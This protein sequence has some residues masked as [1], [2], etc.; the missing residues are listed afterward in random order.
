MV[1]RRET[2]LFSLLLAL[3]FL[4]Y[5]VL[6]SANL[7]VYASPDETANAV[8][9]NQLATHGR[10]WLPESDAPEFAWLHPR[11]WVALNDRIAPVGFLGWPLFVA[12][13]RFVLGP[14]ILPWI[15]ALILLSAAWPFFR[16]LGRFGPAA[17]WI[18]TLVAFTHPSMIL[19]ANRGLFPNG[20]LLAGAIWS[21]W[22]L[23][24][25]AS[26]RLRR[27]WFFLTGAVMAL[28]VAIRPLEALWL[29]PWWVW[30]GWPWKFDRQRIAALFV[31][32]ALVL[33]PT[34]VV[35]D[36]T[37]GSPFA[38]GYWVRSPVVTPTSEQ[39]LATPPSA[40]T[41][42]EPVSRIS[43]LLPFGLH[44][45]AIAWN[46]RHFLLGLVW[47]WTAVLVIAAFLFLRRHRWSPPHDHRGMPFHLAF[48]TVLVLLAVYGSGRYADHVR[49]DAVT[50]ANSFLRY[51][52]PLAPLVGWAIA[53]I[54]NA[55]ERV[56]LF[57][58]AAGTWIGLLA[59]FG[60]FRAFVADDEGL[61]Y[62]RA[63]LFRYAEIRSEA[64]KQ[65]RAGAVIL[66]ERSDKIFFPVLRAVSPMPTK[67]H[68]ASLARSGVDLGLFAR[69]LSQEE[70]DAWLRY[71]LEVQELGA[72]GRETLY[73]LLLRNP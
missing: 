32:A 72:F 34:W 48:W 8:V 66:S 45:R 7:G 43:A 3:L 4:F 61:V 69:P 28:C 49:P 40:V 71:G 73:R 38:I 21:I 10:A 44:P 22:L 52:L 46:S 30:A 56:P 51:L 53:S 9:A 41:P 25:C 5:A 39:T 6:P 67:E 64:L 55:F 14:S 65:F 27:A 63:E 13:F 16:L 37:Y 26:L 11:S 47:P 23:Q 62:T 15:G 31:G 19:Y 17:A 2:V 59:L 12:A 70:R 60:G 50:I 58:L 20:P 35:A 42:A 18:G 24:R 29:V 54:W 68:A 57:R 36:R 1:F 33:V